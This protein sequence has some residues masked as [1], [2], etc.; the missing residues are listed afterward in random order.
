MRNLLITVC[1]IVVCIEVGRLVQSGVEEKPSVTVTALMEP[2]PRTQSPRTNGY[3]LLLG[4][5][6]SPS[7]DPVETGFAMWSEAEIDRGHRYFRSEERRVGK[8]CR[9][10]W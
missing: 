1:I 5:T 8:E 9:S 2:P 10:R 6:T 4:F 7:L 3:L